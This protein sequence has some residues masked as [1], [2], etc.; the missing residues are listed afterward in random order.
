MN[1]VVSAR[2]LPFRAMIKS[3][4]PSEDDF[5]HKLGDFFVNE[6]TKERN[7]L[8]FDLKLKYGQRSISVDFSKEEK[9]HRF[10]PLLGYEQIIRKYSMDGG[11]KKK[12][13]SIRYASHRDAAYLE[14]YSIFLAKK[15]E[16]ILTKLG[17]TDCVLAYRKGGG[18]NI[19]HAKKFFE[20]GSGLNL[21]TR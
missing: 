11:A 2:A 1:G 6:I 18:S 17:I 5:D 21:P 13:R 16:L 12:E 15:Y 4:I 10:Y 9:R 19:D 8:H 14:V 3:F 7:Y 20:L